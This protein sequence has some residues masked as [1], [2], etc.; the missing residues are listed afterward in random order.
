LITAA[1]ASTLNHVTYTSATPQTNGALSIC[2]YKNGGA[3]DP[4]DI[5]SLTVTVVSAD[6]CWGSLQSADGP[7]KAVPGVGD[8]AFGA[9]IG[10]DIKDGNRCVTIDGLTHAELQGN[11]APDVAMGKIILGNLH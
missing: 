11:Y 9:T 1:Q 10:L 5:Q 7:G 4:V 2:T 3:A 8:E 6:S